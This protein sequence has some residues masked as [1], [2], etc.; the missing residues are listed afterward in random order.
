MGARGFGAVDQRP[1]QVPER[2]GESVVTLAGEHADHVV[3]R[4][5][6]LWGQELGVHGFLAVVFEAVTETRAFPV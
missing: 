2:L 4:R 3:G 5:R 6:G 1:K